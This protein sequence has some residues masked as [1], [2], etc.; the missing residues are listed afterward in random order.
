VQTENTA[1]STEYDKSS[2]RKKTADIKVRKVV[3][4]HEAFPYMYVFLHLAIT[5]DDVKCLF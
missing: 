2:N 1:A 4:Y 3:K 5:M